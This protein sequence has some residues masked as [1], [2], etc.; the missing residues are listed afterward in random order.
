MNY[1]STM[2]E[3]LKPKGSRGKALVEALGRTYKTGGFKK[4]SKKAAKKYHSKAAG[5]RVAGAIYWKM[6]EGK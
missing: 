5:D 6:R 1:E 4:I 3:H 2:K